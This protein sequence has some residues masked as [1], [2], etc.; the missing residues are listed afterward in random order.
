M[1]DVAQK[2][3]SGRWVWWS[4]LESRERGQISV[5]ACAETVFAVGLYW[6]IAIHFQT[7]FHLLTSV[8][9]APLLLLRSPQ[10]IEA[11]VR[12]F[13]E[14]WFGF[15]GYQ[16]WHRVRNVRWICVMAVLSGFATYFMTRWL[17][18]TWLPG[19]QG[20]SSFGCSILIGI[21]SESIAIALPLAIAVAPRDNDAIADLASF[22]AMVSIIV[23]STI[24]GTA[25]MVGP[26]VILGV[27][28]GVRVGVNSGRA[29][30]EFATGAILLA[31]VPFL[32]VGFGLGVAIRAL[33]W[34]LAAT[35]H[36]LIPGVQQVPENWR[37]NNFLTDS[38][39][40]PELLP[41]IRYKHAHFCMDGLVSSMRVENAVSVWVFVPI[42]VPFLFLPSFLYRLNIK[43][44]AWFWWP[45]AYLLK[46]HSPV[47]IES[48][49]HQ[50]LCWPWTDPF[51]RFWLCG[52]VIV[53]AISIALL[54]L[55]IHAWW[56][57]RDFNAPAITKIWLAMDWSEVAPWHWIQWG[58]AALGLIML[59]IAGNAL[60]HRNNQAWSD[61]KHDRW[62]AAMTWLHRLRRVATVVWFFLCLIYLLRFSG[63]L[64]DSWFRA[65]GGWSE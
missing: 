23:A 10:S 45:L 11:G 42:V 13:M 2:N 65:L 52:S 21:I 54:T 43:A 49:Q 46:P 35:L 14:D 15:K 37:E 4:S 9:I 7:H 58:S 1:S 44:T 25:A 29:T 33:L 41:N 17:A 12:W 55:N 57:I 3:E 50:A 30:H 59:A 48:Q 62:L 36:F 39:V 56:A 22:S 6:W 40:P 31:L 27:G 61:F 64:P 5:L 60:S 16:Q 32:S 28:L 38:C 53:A 18:Q 51:Q 47:E 34:R 26:V 8:F 19:K 20:L 63:W 24:V